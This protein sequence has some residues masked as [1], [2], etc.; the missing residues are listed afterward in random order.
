VIIFW[1][2]TPLQSAVFTTDQITRI[3]PAIFSQSKILGDSTY[4]KKSLGD[5]LFATAYGAAWL[6]MNPAPF[7]T[8]S[9]AFIPFDIQQHSSKIS[10]TE[11]W[12]SE[13]EVYSSK[14]VCKEGKSAG[15]GIARAWLNHTAA[16]VWKNR[17][18]VVN[19]SGCYRNI[20]FSASATTTAGAGM[21]LN[22]FPT[23][24]VPSG[25]SN[26]VPIDDQGGDCS[27]VDLIFLWA[28]NLELGNDV[29]NTRYNAT[30]LFCKTEYRNSSAQVTID[31]ST[32]EVVQSTKLTGD[33]TPLHNETFNGTFFL[34]LILKGQNTDPSFIIKDPS[35]PPLVSLPTRVSETPLSQASSMAIAMN[36]TGSDFKFDDYANKTALFHLFGD[37]HALLFAIAMSQSMH[38]P[39]GFQSTGV[40]GERHIIGE[41]VIVVPTL[42]RILEGFLATVAVLCCLLL[43]TN[44][45]RSSHLHSD[46]DSIAVK[47]ALVSES[48][49]LLSDFDG[50]D[51]CQDIEKHLPSN[52]QYRLGEWHDSGPSYRLD[53]DGIISIYNHATPP[54]SFLR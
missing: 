48:T 39:K 33:W 36:I 49:R 46:P 38:T 42:A 3:S 28:K 4:Q 41:A 50:L 35:G 37:A 54:K 22:A 15:V 21:I 47:M 43:I 44:A 53:R 14:L 20:S 19:G 16:E 30:S 24:K 26:G 7:T 31:P 8:K 25:M 18:G 45:R 6:G 13:T 40:A 1:V 9:E 10:T 17:T 52:T 32:K 27:D 23:W 51:Q 12:T 5:N 29:R 34:D 11:T 2:L